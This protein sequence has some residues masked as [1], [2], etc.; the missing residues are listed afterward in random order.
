M[1]KCVAKKL[2][3]F[4]EKCKKVVT[5]TFNF[6]LNLLLI[7]AVAGTLG[8]V[9]LNAPKIHNKWLRSNVGERVYRIMML[10]EQGYLLGGGTGFQVIG[11]SGVSYIMTNA[12][13]CEPFQKEGY[14]NVEMKNGRVVPRKILEISKVTDLCLAEGLPGVQGLAV[15][16]QASTGDHLYII[17]HPLLQPL[18]ITQGEIIA[19]SLVEF[20]YAQIIPDDVPEEE[21]E[22]WM[23]TEGQCKAQPKFKVASMTFFGQT[24][25]VCML[26]LMAYEST[27]TSFPGN[28]GSP[29]VDSWG[30]VVG[31]LYAG[32]GMT[33]WGLI[34]TNEDVQN[35]LSAY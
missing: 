2:K 16:N 32:N 18:S 20:P 34:L 22:D 28:S 33:T 12:H 7:C 24:V 26:S 35:F 9:S 10:D 29:V 4:F 23:M 13:V 1:E 21:R 25:K 8:V 30:N 27:I 19:K 15:T 17:G 6:A 31:V 11:R 5:S 14:I 3:S